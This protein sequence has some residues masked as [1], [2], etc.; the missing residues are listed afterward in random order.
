MHRERARAFGHAAVEN[1]TIS[2]FDHARKVDAEVLLEMLVF[3]AD[4]GVFQY[5]RNLV[6]GEQNPAL[7]GESA[8][9][10][11]VVGIKLGDDVGAVIFERV[12]F[13]EVAGIDEQQAETDA[14]ANRAKHEERKDQAAEKAAARDPHARGLRRL[15]TFFHL[16]VGILAHSSG[17]G[18]GMR[19]ACFA[20]R[21]ES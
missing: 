5:L 6:V 2:R 7:E 18:G 20:K 16:Y 3:G 14:Q 1:V 15:R 12:N 8:D 21:T 17:E 4:D 10:L 19:G 13:G 11:A 9:G